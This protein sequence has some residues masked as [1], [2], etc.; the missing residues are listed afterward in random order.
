MRAVKKRLQRIEDEIDI[1][2]GIKNPF[3]P[4]ILEI[5]KGERKFEELDELSF[6]NYI[7]KVNK[8]RKQNYL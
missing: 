2:A 5:L 7:S 1:E 8:R 6:I 4:T 3:S